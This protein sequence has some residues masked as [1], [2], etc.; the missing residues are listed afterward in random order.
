M[1]PAVD[2]YHPPTDTPALCRTSSLVEELGQ[3]E[4]IFSDKT[5]TLTCNQM[6]FRQCSIGGIAYADVVEES[7]RGEVFSFSNL[8]DNLAA[9]HETGRVIREF[10]TLLAT[11]HTV[12]PE[13]KD[14]K[15]TYQASSPDE[16]ALVQGADVLGYTFVVSRESLTTRVPKAKSSANNA[17]APALSQTRK[18]Q[19]VFVSIDGKQ[20]EY[21]ILNILEFNSTRKRMSAVVRTPEGKI[22][23]YCKGADTVIFERLASEGQTFTEATANHLEVST[24]TVECACV[25]T[26]AT[27][28]YRSTP[29]KACALSASPCVTFRRTSTRSGRSCTRER[30]RQSAGAK[31]R[32]TRLPRSLNAICSSSARPRS[33]TSCRTAC[34]RPSIRS[35]RLGS[36]CG[37]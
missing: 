24:W 12:I 9:G 34:P 8:Q 37:S 27:Q 36:R 2:M 28:R 29:P 32:S 16:A 19:S 30:R 31:T 6:E 15:I 35:S 18:P 21:Q 22:K 5:G 4:Y 11:C 33:R 25:T 23:L 7:K 1:C 10:L 14:E 13:Y 20:R 26:D 17:I 3:I